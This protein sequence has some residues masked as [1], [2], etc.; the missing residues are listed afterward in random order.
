[1]FEAHV[2]FINVKVVDGGFSS[3]SWLEGDPSATR[4]T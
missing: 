3:G 1:M 4:M 2:V